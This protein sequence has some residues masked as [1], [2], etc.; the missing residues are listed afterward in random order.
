[1]KKWQLVYFLLRKKEDYFLPVIFQS[2]ACLVAGLQKKNLQL[3]WLSDKNI[4][5]WTQANPRRRLR[6]R[7]AYRCVWH[8][9]HALRARAR[10]QQAHVRS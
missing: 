4:C 1:M 9:L 2:L 3:A 7:R 5:L 6:D 10:E 8:A